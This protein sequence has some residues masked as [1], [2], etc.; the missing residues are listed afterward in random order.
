MEAVGKGQ[1]AEQ[2]L[3]FFH[4]EIN[5]EE[6]CSISVYIIITIWLEISELSLLQ[7]PP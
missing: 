2:L 4:K 5:I 1:K 7:W 3:L 6:F